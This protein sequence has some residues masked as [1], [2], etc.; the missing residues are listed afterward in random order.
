[1]SPIKIPKNHLN[2]NIEFYF[3]FIK[4]NN[5][6]YI[7]NYKN[8]DNIIIKIYK[9]NIKKDAEYIEH[10]FLYF[11][12]IF[13]NCNKFCPDLNLNIGGSLTTLSKV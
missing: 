11:L 9:N 2:K 13:I 6:I 8:I 7:L 10:N 3:D 1:M 5:C 12:Y 4:N